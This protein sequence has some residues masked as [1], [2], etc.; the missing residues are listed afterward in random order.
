[1]NKT[2]V[3]AILVLVVGAGTF[4]QGDPFQGLNGP[5]SKVEQW[6]HKTEEKFG[7]IVEVWDA[8]TVNMYDVDQNN[9]ESIHYTKTGSI[10]NRYIR[11]F[12]GS[13]RMVQI[14]EDNWRGRLET[15]TLH[16]YEGNVQI[17]RSYDADGDLESAVDIE[18]DADGN[19]VRTTMYDVETGDVSAV[20]ENTYTTDGEPL[21][22]RMYDDEGNLSVTFDTCYDAEG[23]DYIT[24]TVIYLLGSVFMKTE[25]GTKIIRTDKYGN[26][27]EKQRYEHKER[28]GKTEW[29]LTNIYRREITYR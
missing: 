7:D 8:H 27:T 2:L 3:A 16:Q 23:M 21:S 29:V 12:D 11:T 13:G 15:K 9:I 5:V 20:W 26:W 22:T 6:S 14:D 28:F 4:G 1:M 18:F 24:M 10:E 17:S 25:S 19:M